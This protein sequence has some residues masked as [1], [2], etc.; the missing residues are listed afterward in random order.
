MVTSLAEVWIEISMSKEIR[1][2]EEVTSL[3]EVW[4]EISLLL[5]TLHCFSPSLP[6]RKCG[7]KF[8]KLQTV[9]NSEL[10]TSL[11]EVWIEI[12]MNLQVH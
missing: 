11:A 2:L 1:E 6:L 12:L 10:V 8:P 9:F 5:R 7:L 3:A 4:I